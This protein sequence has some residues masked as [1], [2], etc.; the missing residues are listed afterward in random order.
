[1]L[2]DTFPKTLTEFDKTFGTEEGCAAY[3]RS[4]KW[5]DGFRCP[6]CG[7]DAAHSIV[8]RKLEQCAKCRHQ[9][10][11]TVGTIFQKTHKPLKLWFRVIFE[12]VSRK[13]GCNAMDLQRLFGLNRRIAWIWL[14]KIRE[15]MDN[16]GRDPL[17]G[18]VEVDETQ[19]GAAEEGVFGRDRGTKKILIAGAVELQE[20]KGCGRARLA[21]IESAEQEPLQTFVGENVEEGST[22]HSDGL[23]SYNGID[24]VFTHEVDVIGKDAKRAVQLFEPI[25]R[26]FSLFKRVL[27]STYQGSMSKKYAAAYCNE[28]CF[29][30][31][32]RKSENRMLLVQRVIEAALTRTSRMH[33]YFGSEGRAY[34]AAG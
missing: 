13:H 2:D 24:A 3:L 4:K 6:A 9:T 33:R 21:P 18:R 29:R 1:M 32:R 23:K 27:I 14:H 12:F 10:S 30:F 31:N 22:V 17:K 34:G 28:F 16:R 15:C 25:H 5:P 26:V 19:V 11:L 8:S 20:P 7:H